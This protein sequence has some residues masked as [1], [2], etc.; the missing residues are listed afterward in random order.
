LRADD[1]PEDFFA[2][3]FEPERE[4]DFLAPDFDDDFD[5]LFLLLAGDLAIAVS[6]R[7][8]S[9]K[10]TGIAFPAMM[11]KPP[12][13]AWRLTSCKRSAHLSTDFLDSRTLKM[14][15]RF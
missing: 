5:E 6:F 14:L 10:G 7:F 1:F 4:L 11:R 15:S 2:P 13:G 3:L 9:K 8:P 12:T